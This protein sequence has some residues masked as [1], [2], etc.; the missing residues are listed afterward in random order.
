MVTQHQGR[1]GGGGFVT[2]TLQL[3]LLGNT[4]VPF[5]KYFVETKE[6][7]NV[8]ICICG[9]LGVSF[10]RATLI[11]AWQYIC[12][13]LNLRFLSKL[14]NCFFFNIEKYRL[15]FSILKKTLYYSLEI[16]KCNFRPWDVVFVRVTVQA[17]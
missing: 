6:L 10:V 12:V 17:I 9:A 5:A 2:L 16:V 13:S 15:Y 4:A 11:S 8:H 1:G 14:K 3:V 7:Q